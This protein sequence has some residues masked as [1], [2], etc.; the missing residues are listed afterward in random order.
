MQ[1]GDIEPADAWAEVINSTEHRW[2][3]C[4]LHSIRQEKQTMDGN[5]WCGHSEEK[6][7]LNQQVKKLDPR[8]FYFTLH[9]TSVVSLL[10]L[11]NAEASVTLLQ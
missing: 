10:L 9:L 6:E 7:D 4:W 8:Y 3:A 2:S 11:P 5:S 1:G